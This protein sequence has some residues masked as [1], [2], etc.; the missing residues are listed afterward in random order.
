SQGGFPGRGVWPQNTVKHSTPG[1]MQ[2]SVVHSLPSSVHGVS[3]G[4]IWQVELQQSP[5]SRLPSSHCSEPLV[6]PTPQTATV[7]EVDEN[8]AATTGGRDVIRKIESGIAMK[9]ETDAVFTGSPFW[10][11]PGCRFDRPPGC[12]STAR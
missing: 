9:R 4:S 12:R 10:A 1:H 11:A 7:V 3:M 6:K 8:W 5:S 2:A